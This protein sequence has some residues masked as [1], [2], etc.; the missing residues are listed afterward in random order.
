MSNAARNARISREIARLYEELGV[1]RSALIMIRAGVEINRLIESLE[2]KQP[3]DNEAY[4][5]LASVKMEAM[6]ARLQ[7]MINHT[8]LTAKAA[9]SLL[10]AQANK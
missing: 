4:Q 2:R 3:P 5:K 9:L 7:E 1:L 6:E 10:L 8:E